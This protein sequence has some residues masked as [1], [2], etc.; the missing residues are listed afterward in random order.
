MDIILP[1]DRHVIYQTHLSIFIPLAIG[2]TLFVRPFVDISC[3][4]YFSEIIGQNFMK[5]HSNDLLQA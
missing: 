1:C 5:I 2:F 4:Y 3:E